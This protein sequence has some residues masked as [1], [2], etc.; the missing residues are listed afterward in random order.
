MVAP[1]IEVSGTDRDKDALP[2]AGS[3]DEVAGQSIR[4]AVYVTIMSAL[5]A[6]RQAGRTSALAIAGV[7]ID[8]QRGDGT[9]TTAGADLCAS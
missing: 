7:A 2:V 1:G 5:P 3:C 9:A 8:A 6:T 4:V